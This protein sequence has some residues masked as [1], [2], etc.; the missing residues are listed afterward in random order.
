M[1]LRSDAK[2]E[3]KSICCFKNDK[4]LIN[5]DPITQKSKKIGLSLVPIVQSV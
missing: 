4:N 2:S 3:E 5:F 1:T